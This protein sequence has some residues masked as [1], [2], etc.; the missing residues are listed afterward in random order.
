MIF[1]NE[2][3][4]TVGHSEI[5]TSKNGKSWTQRD[6]GIYESLMGITYGDGQFVTTGWNGTILTSRDGISWTQ[7]E[8]GTTNFFLEVFYS[9]IN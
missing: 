6:S 8:S 5:L 1:G 7:R 9:Q 3:F 2:I 4:V